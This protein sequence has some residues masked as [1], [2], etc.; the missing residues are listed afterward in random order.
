MS[1]CGLFVEK[2]GSKPWELAGGHFWNASIV[3]FLDLCDGY[4]ILTLR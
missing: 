1:D 4:K 2:G 3:L